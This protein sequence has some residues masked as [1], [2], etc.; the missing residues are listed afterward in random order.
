MELL[1]YLIRTLTYKRSILEL[2]RNEASSD[3]FACDAFYTYTEGQIRGL[4]IAITEIYKLVSEM[5]ND[6]KRTEIPK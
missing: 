5:E 4:S 6:T 1:E 3:G 2:E